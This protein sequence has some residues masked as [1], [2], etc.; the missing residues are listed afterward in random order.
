MSVDPKA[1][2]LTA[3]RVL[4]SGAGRQYTATTFPSNPW[5]GCEHFIRTGLKLGLLKAPATSDDPYAVLDVLDEEGTIVQD[6]SVPSSRAFKWVKRKLALRVESED[7]P[8]PS[9][10]GGERKG[11]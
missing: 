5:Q 10:L 4:P 7:E 3:F 1:H 2:A 9:L 8:A 11:K 6:F